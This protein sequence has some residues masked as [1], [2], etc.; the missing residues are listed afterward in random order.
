M[1]PSNSTF[2]ANLRD[3][4]RN[5]NRCAAAHQHQN[6]ADQHNRQIVTKFS[7]PSF[8]AS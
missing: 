8:V 5:K 3:L 7:A 6:G 2:W 4:G 1:T